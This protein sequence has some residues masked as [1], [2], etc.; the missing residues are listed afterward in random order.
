MDRRSEKLL[1]TLLT[2]A[3]G[4]GLGLLL[5]PKPSRKGEGWIKGITHFFEQR[6]EERLEAISEQMWEES[7]NRMTELVAELL[8]LFEEYEEE[9]EE[10]YQDVIKELEHLPR[11]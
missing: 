1:V 7:R 11:E 9:W 2:V 5:A 10:V 3:G 6:L 4:V 8:P